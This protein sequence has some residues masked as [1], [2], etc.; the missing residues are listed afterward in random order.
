[1]VAF[2]SLRSIL[3]LLG[4]SHDC[5]V[6]IFQYSFCRASVARPPS[7]YVPPLV[8]ALPQSTT[9]RICDNSRAELAEAM[10]GLEGKEGV[11]EIYV[12]AFLAS[13][14]VLALPKGDQAVATVRKS[15]FARARAC[16]VC[17]PVPW[18]CSHGLFFPVCAKRLPAFSR[19]PSRLEPSAR[20][21]RAPRRAPFRVGSRICLPKSR[22]VR[23]D[24]TKRDAES[25]GFVQRTV[26]PACLSRSKRARI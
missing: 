20:Q 13:R 21:S 12:Q 24:A 26:Y 3:R 14:D 6:P 11:E 19:S 18:F 8:S 10:E 23:P 7:P 16:V 17:M 25:R 22:S 9:V 2:H 4:I 1:M 15:S 5:N